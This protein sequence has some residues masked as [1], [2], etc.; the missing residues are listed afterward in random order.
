MGGAH[1][2]IDLDKAMIKGRRVTDLGACRYQTP[3]SMT[4][5]CTRRQVIDLIDQDDGGFSMAVEDEPES[6]QHFRI[7]EASAVGKNDALSRLEK[8]RLHHAESIG[9][10][11]DPLIGRM[12]NVSTLQLE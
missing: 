8:S 2:G 4:E 12:T 10:C 1:P 9:L 3:K 6:S 5:C 7:G 11:P